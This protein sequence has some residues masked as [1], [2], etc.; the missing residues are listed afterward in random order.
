MVKGAVLQQDMVN[1]G[2]PSSLRASI[3]AIFLN[4]TWNNQMSWYPNG[5][6]LG[7]MYH[8]FIHRGYTTQV[9]SFLLSQDQPP[10][11][12][13]HCKINIP[14]HFYTL[15][16][17]KY[18]QKIYLYAG[19]GYALAYSVFNPLTCLVDI[20]GTVNVTT[21]NNVVYGLDTLN[22][23]F[24]VLNYDLQKGVDPTNITTGSYATPH[25]RTCSFRQ[26]IKFRPVDQIRYL[27]GSMMIFMANPGT[28]WAT[29]SLYKV[30]MDTCSLE[31]I[32]VTNLPTAMRFILLE[33]LQQNYL[34]EPS[35]SGNKEIKFLVVEVSTGKVIITADQKYIFD[36][37]H[38]KTFSFVDL[39]NAGL[40]K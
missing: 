10:L 4:E 26:L 17:D 27:D 19:Q 22:K 3:P 23:E 8:L 1:N 24:A 31:Q 15:G 29:A 12:T 25:T 30:N 34:I 21:W 14:D 35:Y 16:V 18:Q 5:V 32:G 6:A 9:Y 33:N 2:P 28:S 13:K 20:S 7:N 39:G 40:S 11:L 38:W 36:D 37:V